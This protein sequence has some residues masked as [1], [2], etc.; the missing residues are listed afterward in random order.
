MAPSTSNDC[1]SKLPRQLSSVSSRHDAASKPVLGLN[2]GICIGVNPPSSTQISLDTLF[3]G[4]S[5]RCDSKEINLFR[6]ISYIC[7][8]NVLAAIPG[9][10]SSPISVEGND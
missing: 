4:A 5:R 7:T 9:L 8:H 2:N 6:F 1:T 10:A 3:K